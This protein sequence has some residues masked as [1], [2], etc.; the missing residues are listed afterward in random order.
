VEA[1]ATAPAWRGRGHGTTVMRDV[2]DVVREGFELGA[3]GTGVHAFY[4]RLG[5]RAWRGP[6][7]VRTPDGERPTPD[8]DGLILVLFPPTTPP[9]ACC[10]ARRRGRWSPE[11]SPRRTAQAP[12]STWRCSLAIT[13]EPATRRG[14]SPTPT[15]AVRRTRG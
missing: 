5:W 1:V 9:R 8:E 10:R 4:E 6:T 2:N 11:P 13:P 3:L 7:A 15:P 12:S 14:R